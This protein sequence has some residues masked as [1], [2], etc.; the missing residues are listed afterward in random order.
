MLRSATEAFTGQDG[1]SNRLVEQC[2]EIADAEY[3]DGEEEE[4]LLCGFEMAEEGGVDVGVV[5]TV[6][7]DEVWEDCEEVEGEDDDDEEDHEDDDDVDASIDGTR[8]E[9]HVYADE[10]VDDDDD[11]SLYDNLASEDA[12]DD[13]LED[14]DD[15]DDSEGSDDT[16]GTLSEV[17]ENPLA[18]NLERLHLYGGTTSRELS[19]AF[20]LY[21][22][23]SDD[24]PSLEDESPTWSH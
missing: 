3:G 5:E 16:Q 13:H 12:D 17:E 1:D 21:G 19:T 14:S 24:R 18:V 22:T 7:A 11:G 6:E 9:M 10:S 15:D 2:H 8:D 4:N 20:P 23:D